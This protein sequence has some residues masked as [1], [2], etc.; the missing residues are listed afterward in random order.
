L[1]D[2]FTLLA[3]TDNSE[4]TDDAH[5]RLFSHKAAKNEHPD[6]RQ[7]AAN[8]GQLREKL[9][10]KTQNVDLPPRGTGTRRGQGA[11]GKNDDRR[12]QGLTSKRYDMLIYPVPQAV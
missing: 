6:E 3:I 4:H 12:S 11:K 1:V 5:D 10:V 7:H 8:Q 9:L 2:G